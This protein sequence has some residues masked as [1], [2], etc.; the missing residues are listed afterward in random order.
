M[1]LQHGFSL[2]EI[3]VTIFIVTLLSLGILNEQF[4]VK[5]NLNTLQSASNDALVHDNALECHYAGVG[6]S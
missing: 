2:I 4:L 3:L 5:K 6:C 1:P